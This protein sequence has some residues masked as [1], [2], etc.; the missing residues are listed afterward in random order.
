VT[1]G[2]RLSAFV[3][4]S[5]AQKDEPINRQ[6]LDFLRSAGIACETGEEAENRQISVKV[7]ERIEAHPLFVGILTRRAALEPENVSMTYVARRAFGRGA[8]HYTTSGWVLQESGYALAKSR[9]IIL[10]VEPGIEFPGLQGDLEYV[11][12][13]RSQIEKTFQKLNEILTNIRSAEAQPLLDKGLPGTAASPGEAQSTEAQ[14]VAI[15]TGKGAEKRDPTAE[16]FAVLAKALYEDRNLDAASAA[17]EVFLGLKSEPERPRWSAFYLKARYFLGDA[18]AFGSLEALAREYPNDPRVQAQF[19]SALEE[20]KAWTQAAESYERAASAETNATRRAELRVA[21]ASAIVSSGDPSSAVDGLSS[22]LRTAGEPAVRAVLLGGLSKLLEAVGDMPSSFALAELALSL[23]PSSHDLRFYLAYAYSA[24]GDDRMA[25]YHY[26]ILEKAQPSGVTLNNLGVALTSLDLRGSGVTAYKRAVVE[27]NETLA[28]A[29]LAD[30]YREGGFVDEALGM[31]EK[32]FAEAGAREVHGNVGKAK[33]ALESM[34]RDEN[35]KEK[36][37]L[38]EAERTRGFRATMAPAIVDD[39][40]ADFGGAWMW[41]RWDCL[42]L[43]QVGGLI[44][45]EFKEE[46]KGHNMFDSPSAPLVV[47]QTR[48]LKLSGAVRGRYASLNYEFTTTRQYGAD[49]YE[50]G[51]IDVALD[52]DGARGRARQESP[53]ETPKY[54]QIRRVPMPE[55]GREGA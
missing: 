32:A 47:T 27:Q 33:D 37:I 49:M 40:T 12:L 3:G 7:R 34:M 42:T 19:A 1:S 8:D 43:N 24:A 46:T 45:G 10:L 51:T 38:S 23:A 16:A 9:R 35:K 2:S 36:G 48:K 25:L 26:R 20:I 44:T 14:P 54:Y 52:E 39:I 50:K 15:A 41:D 28:M 31:I 6:I 29:N 55:S 18:G 13:H 11:T 53:G 21:A 17:F 22:D 4:Q 30:K 5:F